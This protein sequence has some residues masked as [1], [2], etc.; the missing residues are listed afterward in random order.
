MIGS[1]LNVCI[2]RIPRNES[3]AFPGSHCTTCGKPIKAYDLIPVLSFLFLGGKCR[4]CKETISVRYPLVELTTAVL[5]TSQAWRF[6]ITPEFFFY[7][8]MTAVLI[9]ITMIDLDLQIIPD[10]LVAALG[11]LGLLYVFFIRFP[12]YGVSTLY[13]SA[14]GFVIGGLFFL[15]IAIVSNGGMGGGD[16]KLMAVL[17][18]WFGWQKLL[19]LMFLTFI[20]GAIISVFLLMKAKKMKDGIP[21]GPFIAFAA[22]IV[23]IFGSGI[24]VWY[25]NI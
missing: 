14:I 9:V 15:L 18:L 21:F 24:I 25:L 19:V 5:I 16:I 7:A 23:S 8:A 2:Y 13:N 20:S 3:I 11:I 22:Y 10:R 1:F 4:M 17:G 12:Q 6:G